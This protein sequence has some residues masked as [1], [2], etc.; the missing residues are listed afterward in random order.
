MQ[1]VD[2]DRV[3]DRRVAEFVEHCVKPAMEK[4]KALRHAQTD[5]LLGW[6]VMRVSRKFLPMEAAAL[7][8]TCER[9]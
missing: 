8:Q 6:I 4:N 7:K 3:V 1:V 9:A 5:V 2:V